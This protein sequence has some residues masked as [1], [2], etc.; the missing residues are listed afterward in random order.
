MMRTDTDVQ[1]L[2]DA[3]V[4]QLAWVQHW[5]QDAA[6]GLKPTENSLRKALATINDALAGVDEHMGDEWMEKY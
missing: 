2:R 3:L 6:H 1:R 4:M 5:Q